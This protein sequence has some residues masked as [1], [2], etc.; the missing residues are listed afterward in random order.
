MFNSLV[1]LISILLLI[2]IF[3]LINKSKKKQNLILW[4]VISLIVLFC[5][6]SIIVY[7]LSMF[8]IKSNLLVL[9]FINIIVSLL[10]FMFFIKNKGLQKYYYDKKDI[11]VAIL[12]AVIIIIIAYFRFGFPFQIVYETVDPGAHFWKCMDFFRES[13]LLNKSST[14]ID[15]STRFFASYV[16]VGLLFKSVEPVVGYIDLYIIYIMYD[17]YSLFISTFLFYFLIKYISKNKN[18]I[19]FFISSILYMLGYPLNNLVFGFFYLG[20][21]IILISLIIYMIKLYEAKELNIKIVITLILILN[22]GICFT[23]YLFAPIVFIAEFL[24]FGYIFK[25]KQK[26]DNKKIFK[27]M[28]TLFLLPVLFT[29]DYYF[30]HNIGSGS[31]GILNQLKLDGYFFNSWLS[32]FIVFL[33]FISYYIINIEKRKK[34]DFTVYLFLL[35]IILVIFILI[36]SFFNF[37]VTY[38]SSK[39]FYVLWLLC[40]ILIFE[41]FN[42]KEI[43]VTFKNIYMISFVV[44]FVF[45]IFHVEDYLFDN[46]SLDENKRQSSNILDVYSFNIDKFNQPII[47][48]NANEIAII[49]VLHDK[50]ATNVINN[51]N[52]EFNHQRIWLNAFFWKDKMDYPENELYDYINN[53]EYFVDPVYDNGFYRMNNEY[54]YYLVLYR[55]IAEKKYDSYSKYIPFNAFYRWSYNYRKDYTINNKSLYD[56]ISR[57]DCFNCKFFDFEDGMIIIKE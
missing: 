22:I 31:L 52:I 55:D 45:S 25:K 35:T 14:T 48:F 12:F 2:T 18:T 36:L 49:K 38:Y 44:L 7:I 6:N 13:L 32:N 42:M 19:I 40:F 34:V 20:H 21:T 37:A 47:T 39:F 4:I 33:P 5:Y 30:L 26:L 10:L 1:Y 27:S 9:T 15:F 50:G 16:N 23:Y 3:L 24:Y 29:L 53:Y 57:D 56:E 51:F 17:L 8:N 43:S 41:L 28:L 46:E 11:I 54:K